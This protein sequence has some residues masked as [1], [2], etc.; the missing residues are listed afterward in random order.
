MGHPLCKIPPLSNHQHPLKLF[1][2]ALE[3]EIEKS[4]KNEKCEK[5]EKG[6]K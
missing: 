5:C 2:D 4:E 3:G 6:K 1:D